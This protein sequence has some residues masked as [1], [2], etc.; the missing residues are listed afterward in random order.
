M[1]TGGVDSPLRVQRGKREALSSRRGGL[2]M[3]VGGVSTHL[4][5][6]S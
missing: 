3:N 1:G 5:I 4:A 2:E 6:H